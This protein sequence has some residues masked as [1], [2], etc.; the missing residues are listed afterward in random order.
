MLLHNSPLSRHCRHFSL[1][2]LLLAMVFELTD[3]ARRAGKLAR[4]DRKPD[5]VWRDCCDRLAQLEIGSKNKRSN[6]AGT[7]RRYR[8]G[9]QRCLVMDFCKADCSGAAVP[10]SKSISSGVSSNLPCHHPHNAADRQRMHC[11]IGPSDS[12]TTCRTTSGISLTCIWSNPTT[13]PPR[14]S[15]WWNRRPALGL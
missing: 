14:Q 4:G 13:H 9:K 1:S 11:Y 5:A 3:S 8:A 12:S 15:H 10:T 2:L 7:S 6:H